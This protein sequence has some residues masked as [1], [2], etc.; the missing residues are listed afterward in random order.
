M[1]SVSRLETKKSFEHAPSLPASPSEY[2]IET[3][4]AN[5]EWTITSLL[6]W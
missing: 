2:N 1:M 4:E 3:F 5:I 6:S